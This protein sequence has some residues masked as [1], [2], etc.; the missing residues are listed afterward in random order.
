[1]KLNS[2]ATV[3]ALALTTLGAQAVE[4]NITVTA[5]IDPA[6]ELTMADGTPLP[7]AITMGYTPTGGLQD[8]TLST[9]IYSNDKAKDITMS[10]L[11]SPVL[12]NT[13][14]SSKTI[15]LTV[16]YNE[17][18]VTTTPW[19]SDKALKASKIFL[20]A[21]TTSVAMPL[22]ISADN[23]DMR[24]WSAGTYQGVVSLLVKQLTPATP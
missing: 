21:D 13:V 24:T 18:P 12:T 6:L 22:T 7:T 15:P 5:S 19:A 1:M 4:K 23:A 14:D 17:Q 9:R 11:T 10:L 20:D 2:L 3:F 16:T 8:Y